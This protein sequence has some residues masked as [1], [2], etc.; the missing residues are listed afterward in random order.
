MGRVRA[1]TAP[2]VVLFVTVS[3]PNS[4]LVSASTA[5]ASPPPLSGRAAPSITSTSPLS[6]FPNSSS[7][8]HHKRN[9]GNFLAHSIIKSLEQAITHMV[10]RSSPTLIW[11]ETSSRRSSSSDINNDVMS[12]GAG[13]QHVSAMKQIIFLPTKA[14]ARLK[15]INPPPAGYYYGLQPNKIFPYHSSKDVELDKQLAMAD[16]LAETLEEMRIMRK[17]LQTLRREMYEM[18]KK[19]TG[20]EDLEF[21][22]LL[23][24]EVDPEVARLAKQ[25]RQRKFDKIGR[26]VEDWARRMLFEEEREGN[27]WTEVVCNK[28]VRNAYNADGRT[29]CYLAWLKDARGKHAFKDDDREYP[30]IKVYGTIDAPLEDVCTYLSREEYRVEYNDIL[31]DHRDLEEIAPHAKITWAVSPQVL[32]VKPREFVTFVSHKWS[33]D[34]NSLALINQACEHK[35][36][37][38]VTEEGKGKIC[39]AYALRGGTFLSRDSEDPQRTRM[40]LISQCAPG[41][42]IPPWVRS[43]GAVGTSQCFLSLRRAPFSNICS[44]NLLAGYKNSDQ[45]GN[46]Y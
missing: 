15:R 5:S 8:H 34:G 39:R 9:D 35:D 6:S 25:K 28:V 21:E 7:A 43:F 45:C 23:E 10:S 32:F 4:D 19:I 40:A 17:E 13:V 42:G 38:A 24:D 37:P 3:A 30:C 27:G 33:K 2:A 18:R 26:E 22:G 11:E 36:A 16:T 41:G 1:W 46:A 44:S 12:H 20:E 31:E 14:I 29:S